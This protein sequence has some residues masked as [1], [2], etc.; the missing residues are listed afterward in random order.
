MPK[1]IFSISNTDLSIPVLAY[2]AIFT[3]VYLSPQYFVSAIHSLKIPAITVSLC[4]VYVIIG[5]NRINYRAIA[6]EMAVMIILAFMF[7][8]TSLVVEDPESAHAYY[9][10]HW[11][12]IFI[13]LTFVGYFRKPNLLYLICALFILYVTHSSYHAIM[14]GGLLWGHTFMQD[15]N[16][17]ST[18]MSMMIPFTFF[19]SM[20][21][22]KKIYKLM[23]YGCL[24]MQLALI[25]L[26]FSRGGLLALMTV[27]GGIFFKTKHKMWIISLIIVG[28]VSVVSFAPERFFEEARSIYEEG[29][30]EG[31]GGQRLEYW[32]RAWLMFTENPIA[33]KGIDQFRELSH[34]YAEPDKILTRA[35][36]NV[37]HSNWFQILSELGLIGILCYSTLFY[38][39]FRSTWSMMKLEETDFYYPIEPDV[40]EF[41]KNLST[42]LYIG[43]IG[44]LV[45]ATFLNLLL[46]PFFYT[47]I[48]FDMTLRATV[49]DMM[50]GNCAQP[51][52]YRP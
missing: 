31:T 11:H 7:Y 26:S 38:Q 6:K 50:V 22:K 30:Q 49:S 44:Y 32:R 10:E 52:V 18:L 8:Y 4:I 13:G 39:Y 14:Q 3:H 20:C 2:L 41:L 45:S 42:G 16:Q 27:V 21:L 35:D 33:G 5:F 25:I 36:Y 1:S 24:A 47:F 28:I 23:C 19:F 46:F 51:S 9:T 34:Q 29:G 43:M 12:A 40:L 48:F 37:C 17:I 15:E